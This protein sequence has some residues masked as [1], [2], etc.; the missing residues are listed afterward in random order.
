[1]G[2]RAAM[3]APG[4]EWWSGTVT[5]ERWDKIKDVLASALELAPAERTGYLDEE[6][7]GDDRLRHDVEVLLKQDQKTSADFLSQ[8]SFAE[9]VAALLP[10]E[11]SPWIG[12]RVGAYQIVEKIGVGGMGEVYRAH[13]ADDQYQKEVA[14]KVV[15]A[16]QDSE[17]VLSRFKNERQI[18]A[19]LEHPNIA[20]LLDGGTTEDGLPYFVMELVE[21]QPLN[22]YCDSHQLQTTGRLKLFLQACSAVQYAHQRLIIHRDLKPSNILVTAGGT[23]KLL[24]FGIAKLLDTESASETAEPTM[25]MFRLLTTSYASPEQIRG[26]ALTTVSDVYSLGVVLYELLCGRH[27]YRVEGRAPHE[28]AKAV[29]ES[30][31][32][33]PSAVS[34]GSSERLHRDLRGDLDNIVLMALRKEPSR[35]YSS[36]EHL[37]ADIQRHLDHLPV[38]ARKDTASYRM[39]KFVSRHKLGV[40]ASA[41]VAISIVSGLAV[42]LHEAHVAREQ[43]ELARTQGMRA[44]RR[45]N[46]VRKLAHSLMFDIHDRIQDLPG[47]GPTRELLLANAIEYLDSLAAEG[48]NEASLLRELATGYERIG[49]LQG[50]YGY[51]NLGNTRGGLV[52]YEKALNI[53]GRLAALPSAGL[54]DQLELAACYRRVAYQ[55]LSVGDTS[56]AFEYIE[57]A[58]TTVDKLADAQS[59]N[60]DVLYEQGFVYEI[61]GHIEGGNWS[62]V[63]L[64]NIQNAR[65]D[66]RRAVGIDEAMLKTNPSSRSLNLALIN[67]LV[68]FGNTLRALGNSDEAASN[69]Q[70]ALEIS[71]RLVAHEDIPSTRRMLGAVKDRIAW[72]READGQWGD[73]LRYRR[74][75]VQIYQKLSDADPSNVLAKQDL[76]NVYVD[77]GRVLANTG[78]SSQALTW[79][80]RGIEFNETVQQRNPANAEQRGI[81]AQLYVYRADALANLRKTDEAAHDYQKALD[82]YAALFALSATNAHAQINIAVCESRLGRIFTQRGQSQSAIQAYD[83]ALSITHADNVRRLS[84]PEAAFVDEETYGQLAILYTKLASRPISKGDAAKEYSKRAEAARNQV[85]AIRRQERRTTLVSPYLFNSRS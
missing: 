16:G 54:D 28:V 29:C 58:L 36:T 62:A 6:C 75:L 45:F 82:I 30:E 84:N 50:H 42:A 57:R 43:A 12:R 74:D 4:D 11:E 34:D 53:R 60:E 46:D 55:R 3:V 31:P 71:E 65:D 81:L 61:R 13:R 33:K 1:M 27:P 56:L 70:R 44:E 69:Y 2:D 85:A 49:D 18:L 52:S 38:I 35:R 66:Y 9:T 8:T 32:E 68:Y 79:M 17:L 51:A 25:S 21:G 76:G 73:A 20:R 77:L 41:V 48:G 63:D 40:L 15:R 59:V 26:E 23:P 19:G 37:A 67:D 10:E 78:Q 47:S 7:A 24:D 83:H 80:N 14:L 5:P 22:E 39:S 64:G 72:L